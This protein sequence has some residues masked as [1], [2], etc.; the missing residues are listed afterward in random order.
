LADY[1]LKSRIS[2]PSC[3]VLNLNSAAET[4]LRAE[5]GLYHRHGRINATGMRSDHELRRA[6]HCA[7]ADGTADVPS[8]HAFTCV[9]P[10]GKRPYVIHVVPLPGTS[11][12]EASRGPAALALIIDPE[13]E[14]ESATTL[15][16]RLYG[17]TATEA[18]VALRISRGI[19]LKQISDELSVS[20]ETIRTHVQ[21]VFDKTD[22]H[23]QGE[24]VRLLVAQRP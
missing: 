17:L 22:T 6:L 11:D 9:R 24:L 21:H 3:L 12:D 8:G 20:Y 13:R 16:R 5:D 1:G 4:I 19:S 15:L 2:A 18:E 14:S 7:L 10:S 23:R